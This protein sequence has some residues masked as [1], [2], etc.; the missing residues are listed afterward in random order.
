MSLL[1]NATICGDAS[2]Q[3]TN[4]GIVQTNISVSTN[5]PMK[6]TTVGELREALRIF[7]DDWQVIFGCEELEFYR[8]KK[9]GDKLVQIE[10]R[11]TVSSDGKR[12]IVDSHD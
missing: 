12:I 6:T 1:D 11:Q 9:R 8:T 7:P 4:L 3:K 10:F 2:V 5:T